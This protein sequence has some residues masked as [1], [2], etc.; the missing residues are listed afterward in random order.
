MTRATERRAR[1][2]DEPEPIMETNFFERGR[3]RKE[4]SATRVTRPTES[5]AQRMLCHASETTAHKTTGT[6]KES[7]GGQFI[8][9]EC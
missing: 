8:E 3:E 7:V 1:H 4:T 9:A 5:D 6:R 2:R